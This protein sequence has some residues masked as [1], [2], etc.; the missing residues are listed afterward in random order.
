MSLRQLSKNAFVSII[1]VIVS[2]ALLFELYRF[3]LRQLGSEQ[4]GVWSLVIASTAIARLGESG[5]GGGVTKF[6]AGDLGNQDRARAASTISMSAVAT[7]VIIGLICL[8]VAPSLSVGLAKL[9]ARPDLLASGQALLPWALATLWLGSVSQ[10]FLNALDACQRSDLKAI[11]VIIGAIGQILVAYLIVP[12]YGLLGLGSVQLAQTAATMAVA[13]VYLI[14]T[15]KPD[16]GAWLAYD[17]KRFIEILRYGGGFQFSAIGILLFDPTVKALLAVFGGLG[18]TGFY[19][20]ANRAVGQF[21]AIIVEGYH[22]LV[23]YL[24]HR[25]ANQ[26]MDS[27]Q[28][29]STYRAAHGLL[30][31]IAI[32]G[33]ALLAAALPA[34][35]TLWLGRYDADFVQIGVILTIGGLINTLVISH[36][37]IFLAIGK[38]RW[39]IWSHIAIGVLNVLF[40][41]LG[42]WLY[43]GIGVVVGAMAALALGSLV[44]PIAFHREFALRL[45]D[46]APPE[47]TPLFATSLIGA[48]GLLGLQSLWGLQ[49]QQS[50]ILAGLFVLF[51]LAC[52]LA[53]W[54]YPLTLDIVRR[55]RERP[56]A[57]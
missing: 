52:L 21:R 26:E 25:A 48:A 18:L 24:A 46:F 4:I 45:R 29:V 37:F 44:L 28:M 36:Y 5:I 38:L 47:I 3:L 43:G 1:Q 17:R 31:A 55:L 14:A 30:L 57:V 49:L 19:E 8:A 2:A 39:N 56:A 15:L 34:I 41:G 33:Y 23:P 54:R 27:A 16:P 7:A 35:F 12:R 50:L 10:I 42:G 20:M 32:P 9:I 40:A 6:V 53:F 51:A 22:V 13:I 11:A